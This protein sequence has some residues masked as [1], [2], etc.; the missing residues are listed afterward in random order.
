MSNPEDHR[1]DLSEAD[2]GYEP[3]CD[4]MLEQKLEECDAA[5][6][7]SGREYQSLW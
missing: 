5:F 6:G 3:E 4:E 7:I 1:W 2:E